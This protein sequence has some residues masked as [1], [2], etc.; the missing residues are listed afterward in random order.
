[1][2]LV[3]SLL[4]NWST[5]QID[6]VVAFSQATIE[7]DLYMKLPPGIVLAEGN[8]DTHILLHHKNMYGQKQPGRIWKSNLHKGIMDIG[9][10]QYNIDE[11]VYTKKRHNIHDLFRRRDHYC[12]EK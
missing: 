7:F 2:L 10:T 5:R 3:L 6:F 11:C 9:F 12:R 1:M 4:N 8:L